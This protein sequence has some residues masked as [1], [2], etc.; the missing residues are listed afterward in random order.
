MAQ[1]VPPHPLGTLS[2]VIAHQGR[3]TLAHFFVSTDHHRRLQGAVNQMICAIIETV[4]RHTL[5][6]WQPYLFLVA[7]HSGAHLIAKIF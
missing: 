5:I 4:A 6:R 2:L 3:H 1:L 7:L